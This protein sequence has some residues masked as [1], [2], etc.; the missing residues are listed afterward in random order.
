VA[1]VLNRGMARRS[2]RDRA[3]A[4]VDLE[5][6]LELVPESNKLVPAVRRTLAELRS[7]EPETP[8]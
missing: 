1:A 7:Q 6:V 4:I 2:A 3:G 5:R 8:R